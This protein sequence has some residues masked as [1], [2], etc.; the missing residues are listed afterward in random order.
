MIHLFK[1]VYV[2]SDNQINLNHDRVVISEKHGVDLTESLKNVFPG[3]LLECARNTNE[4][5][6]KVKTWNYFFDLIDNRVSNTNKPFMI[7]CDDDAMIKILIIWFKNLLPNSNKSSIVNLIRGMIFKYNV[8]FKDR[9][10][11]NNL[12]VDRDI[13]KILNVSPLYEDVS[14]QTFEIKDSLRSKSGVEFLLATYLSSGKM[15]DELKDI[16]KILIKKDLEK[17]LFEVK[18]IFFVHLLTRRFAKKLNFDKEYNYDNIYEIMQDESSITKLFLSDKIWNYKYMSYASSENTTINLSE[19]TPEDIKTLNQFVNFASSCWNEEGVYVGPKSDVNK[20]KFITI[21]SD[22][23]DELL[24][25]I[26]QIESEFEHSAGSF[27][28]IDLQSVNHYL[29]T[30]ILERHKSKDLDWIKQYSLIK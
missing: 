25:E 18:E 9:S 28:A 14:L 19:F 7:Y 30:E 16:L 6:S 20:M 11:L 24:N 12:S 10:V 8:F 4:L 27:F 1:K 13:L 15:K 26:I 21:Y 23:N 22:F 17:F 29:I 3:Q 5:L 2:I